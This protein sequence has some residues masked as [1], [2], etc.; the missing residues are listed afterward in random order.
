MDLSVSAPPQEDLLA[1]QHEVDLQNQR[2]AVEELMALDSAE[3]LSNEQPSQSKDNPSEPLVLNRT[4][5]KFFDCGRCSLRCSQN[6]KLDARQTIFDT[7]TDLSTWT[8]KSSYILSCIS[9]EPP[10]RHTV[11]ADNEGQFRKK[12]T[13]RYSLTGVQVCRQVFVETLNVD[14]NR[15]KRL[16]GKKDENGHF[17]LTYRRGL[18]LTA[19][20]KLESLRT[21]LSNVIKFKDTLRGTFHFQPGVTFGSV[22]EEYKKTI[23]DP[24]G[25]KVFKR[26][27]KKLEVSPFKIPA[28]RVC[29]ELK[30]DVGKKQEWKDHT[31]KVKYFEARVERVEKNEDIYSDTLYFCFDIEKNL[32]LPHLSGNSSIFRRSFWL[33]DLIVKDL[34]LKTPATAF[35]W[36]EVEGSWSGREICSALNEFLNSKDLDGISKVESFSGDLVR[37]NQAKLRLVSFLYYLINS[38]A[39]KFHSSIN[40]TTRPDLKRGSCPQSENSI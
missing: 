5:V 34:T 16:L 29:L 1:L 9:S 31:Q 23:E 28:C 22:Y 18:N 37:N 35:L 17:D 27:L 3:E 36:T 39:S 30:N 12:T 8:L 7:F 4:A 40:K 21:F 15:V 33:F 24:V 19:E 2:K 20:H 14:L 6:L 32:P 26:E 10:K 13:F 25:L 38:N 11:N